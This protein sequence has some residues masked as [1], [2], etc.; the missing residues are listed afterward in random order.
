M[1]YDLNG[2]FSNTIPNRMLNEERKHMNHEYLHVNN[3]KATNI[4]FHEDSS[5]THFDQL[6]Q[7]NHGTC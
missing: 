6:I 2:L 7:D 3:A 5:Q 1:S 4:A